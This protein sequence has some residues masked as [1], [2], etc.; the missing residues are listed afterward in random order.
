MNR[1]IMSIKTP[2]TTSSRSVRNI[3]ERHHR[4]RPLVPK[5]E[6]PLK[7]FGGMLGLGNDADGQQ[8]LRRICLLM[9]KNGVLKP[10]RHTWALASHTVSVSK[11]L[12]K[13]I[14]LIDGLLLAK[15]HENAAHGRT[16]CCCRASGY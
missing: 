1:S 9:N 13:Y 15:R 11:G 6:R 10:V 14:A 2:L 8:G 5:M 7:R 3:L 12:E 4:D 16:R